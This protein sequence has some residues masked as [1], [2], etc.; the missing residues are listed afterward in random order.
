[1]ALRDPRSQAALALATPLAAYAAGAA[2]AIAASA[3]ELRS[4]DAR[5]VA[6]ALPAAIVL[7]VLRVTRAGSPRWARIAHGVLALPILTTPFMPHSSLSVAWLTGGVLSLLLG[8]TIHAARCAWRMGGKI[9]QRSALAA[10]SA[11]SC[12]YFFAAAFVVLANMQLVVAPIKIAHRD[13]IRYPGEDEIVLTADDG[14]QLGATYS[15]GRDGA[16]GVVLVH[17]VADGRSR[18]AP[19]AAV[20]AARGYHVLRIDL[21][22]H[23]TSDGAVCSYGQY[24]AR[25]VHAAV[26]YLRSRGVDRIAAV[27]Q[28]MGGGTIL[29]ALPSLRADAIMLLAPAS[30]YPPLVE[31]RVVWLGPLAPPVLRTSSAIARAMGLVPMTRWEPADRLRARPDLPML[32]LHGDRDRA[33]PLALSRRLVREHPRGE[34]VVMRGVGHDEI[35]D[36]LAARGAHWDHFAAFLARE[37]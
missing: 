3:L 16:P 34:L 6:I 5:Y 11:T 31:Q 14:L 7:V 9:A 28:S 2:G 22:A 32:V 1:M 23:G 30:R 29:A 27:G 35:P 17:G 19:L 8:A 15:R 20:L 13:P 12:A 24:E 25:D 37:L 33:I 21:R 26:H 10:L 18:F 4:V 36:L